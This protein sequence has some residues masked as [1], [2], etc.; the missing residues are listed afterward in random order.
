MLF[1]EIVAMALDTLPS[2]GRLLLLGLLLSVALGGAA[3]AIRQ[4]PE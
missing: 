1:F 2:V 4:P 3:R